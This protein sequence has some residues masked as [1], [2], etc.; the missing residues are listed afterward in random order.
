MS[1]PDQYIGIDEEGFPHFGELRVTDAS[2]GAEILRNLSFAENG[3]FQTTLQERSAIVEAFDDP[4][5]AAQVLKT[6]SGWKILLPY[7]VELFFDPKTLTLDEWDRFHGYAENKM[8]FVFSRKA[9]AEFFNLLDEFDDDSITIDGHRIEVPPWLEPHS[10]VRSESFWSQIYRSEKPGWELDQP[11]PAL[12]DMIPRL[13]LPKSRVLVLGCGSG[14]DAA[15]FAR[16]GHVVTAVDISSEALERGK[17]KY[18]DLTNITWI[19]CDAFQ[20]GQ[21]HIG[22]YDLIFEHTCYCAIDPAK[23]NELIHVWKKCLA[24]GGFLL[25]VFFTMEKKSGPPFGAT[26]WELRERLKKHFQ[27]VFWGRWHQS[28]GKRNG[29][30][31]LVY[32]NKR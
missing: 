22:A 19:E 18:S 12:V 16:H 26:E 31:T 21:D 3:A 4:Y 9:Q 30:E 27:F 8:P 15:H 24:P 10:E 7:G 5:V 23:R 32:A 14:N 6:G 13:K 28:I 29:K 25:G 1:L 2:V 17:Q 20:L 11:N